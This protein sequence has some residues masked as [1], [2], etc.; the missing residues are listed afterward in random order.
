MSFTKGKL[1]GN[2]NTSVIVVLVVVVWIDIEAI[3]A[4]VGIADI[5]IWIDVDIVVLFFVVAAGFFLVSYGAVICLCRFGFL[6]HEVCQKLFT[7]VEV[8]DVG[9]FCMSSSFI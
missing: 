4:Y 3:G 9:S 7:L 6:T 5:V 2:G 1:V 8:K